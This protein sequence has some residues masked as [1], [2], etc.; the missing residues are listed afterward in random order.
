MGTKF[1]YRGFRNKEVHIRDDRLYSLF[2]ILMLANHIYG[3]CPDFYLR[4][5]SGFF[6]EVGVTFLRLVFNILF[7]CLL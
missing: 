2:T 5:V 3:Q 1:K 4:F 7:I 6:A